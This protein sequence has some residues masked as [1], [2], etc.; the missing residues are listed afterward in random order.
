MRPEIKPAGEWGGAGAREETSSGSEHTGAD[1]VGGAQWLSAQVLQGVPLPVWAGGG[2]RDRGLSPVLPGDRRE[3]PDQSPG[4]ACEGQ[5]HTDQGRAEGRE[6]RPF[7][8]WALAQPPAGAVGQGGG[9]DEWGLSITPPAR[10]P[11]ETKD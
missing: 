8:P 3:W 5:D 10:C 2:I 11:H 6:A 9:R 7:S 1:P 4:T